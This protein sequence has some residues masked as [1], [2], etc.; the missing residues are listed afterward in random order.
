M[1]VAGLKDSPLELPL[2]FGACYEA[3]QLTLTRTERGMVVRSELD[4]LLASEGRCEITDEVVYVYP[5]RPS[6]EELRNQTGMQYRFG[7]EIP[8][9]DDETVW[10]VDGR[11]MKIQA[12]EYGDILF[13]GS[14]RARSSGEQEGTGQGQQ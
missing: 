12:G 9:R 4:P 13:R 7:E 3:G 1:D 5:H 10:I 14:G 8:V 2:L 11:M 6:V